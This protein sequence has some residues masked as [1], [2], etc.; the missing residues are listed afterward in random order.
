[1]FISY[2]KRRDGPDAR[3]L[4]ASLAE[5]G[6]SVWFDEQILNRKTS[7]RMQSKEELMLLLKDAINASRCVVLFAIEVGVISVPFD[8]QKAK[9]S[10]QVMTDDLGITVAWNWQLFEM[11]QSQRSLVLYQSDDRGPEAVAHRLAHMGIRPGQ[12]VK[13]QSG[14]IKRTWTAICRRLNR[15][16]RVKALFTPLPRPNAASS[17]CDEHYLYR[18]QFWLAIHLRTLK[19][20]GGYS[21]LIGE[22]GT[23]KSVL[24]DRVAAWLLCF[25][26]KRAMLRVRLP[27][28]ED[29]EA[30]TKLAMKE[31]EDTIF[32]FDDLTDQ[33]ENV[34]QATKRLLWK[35]IS[36]VTWRRLDSIVVLSSDHANEILKR[37]YYSISRAECVSG[38]IHEF[39][40]ADHLNSNSIMEVVRQK[41]RS[42]VESG[43][44]EFQ[45][46]DWSV[47]TLVSI[48]DRIPVHSDLRPVNYQTLE[49]SYL[50]EPSKSLSV[51][52][53]VIEKAKA[54]ARGQV[55]CVT[56][57]TFDETV[58]N[59]TGFPMGHR[60]ERVDR[61]MTSISE[62]QGLSQ[63][64][65]TR[66]AEFAQ[67]LSL[68]MDLCSICYSLSSEPA[69][70]LCIEDY[71]KR[72]EFARIAAKELLGSED[73]VLLMD[74][75][76]ISDQILDGTVPYTETFRWML[77]SVQRF[78][79]WIIV[80]ESLHKA[81][82]E[83]RQG[84][85][86]I[87]NEGQAGFGAGFGTCHARFGRCV[88]V[89]DTVNCLGDER[90]RIEVLR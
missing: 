16:R 49:G 63:E 7:W 55:A 79:W 14:V 43:Q 44:V 36:H 66:S 90:R 77:R 29:I 80:F 25:P 73:A 33:L 4:A 21:A 74:Y 58:G 47:S 64:G 65:K 5:I 23:G 30:W 54:S 46:S 57:A 82:K 71:K 13:T 8:A 22:P 56:D 41:W 26:E 38:E 28:L 87:L 9:D 27:A 62:S 18:L 34:S 59:I 10:N 50:T 85:R 1:V 52:N 51:L 20:R 53:A 6:Y 76:V 48:L 35:Q 69:F 11:R 75:E 32:V 70:S 3:A 40:V 86:A 37:R 72:R 88:V 67:L 68:R 61:L 31:P 17:S 12:G 81:S 89:F 24:I 83:D 78:P 60:T 39:H 2:T 42:Y 84:V 15:E 19:E 45:T